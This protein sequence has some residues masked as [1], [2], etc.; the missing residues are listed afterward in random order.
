MT[1]RDI[2]QL[3]AANQ[4]MGQ[5][6]SEI[7][8]A[9]IIDTILEGL[10][11][12]RQ[13]KLKGFGTF[14]LTSVKERESVNVN[15]GERI[16]ISEH[17]KI[18]FTP[19]NVMRDTINKPFAQFETV[20]L[21]DG[22]SFADTEDETLKDET[23][24]NAEETPAVIEETP[25]IEETPVVIEE[26]PVIEE[27]HATEQD[28][29]ISS[30]YEHDETEDISQNADNT[31]TSE[32]N[33]GESDESDEND[34]ESEVSKEYKENDDNINNDEDETV[35]DDQTDDESGS[36][37]SLKCVLITL[38]MVVLIIASFILGFLA[39]HYNWFALNLAKAETIECPIDTTTQEVADKDTTAITNEVQAPT[40]TGDAAENNKANIS[41]P[42]AEN[43]SATTT[44]AK[45]EP[46]HSKPAL[47]EEEETAEKYN[48]ADIRIRTGAYNII[49]IENTITATKG[50]T[51][52]S[53]SKAY[54]GQDMECYIEAVNGGIKELNGGEKI[55]IP[56]L[57][58]KKKH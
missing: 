33:K 32:E 24:E 10:Q 44:S 16:T 37:C 20:T 57:Q 15:T 39:S 45:A 50:Q 12:D 31:S 11:R 41:A 5:T 26:N 3:I 4:G 56:K 25:A 9:A 36:R 21:A 19:D 27:E 34:D 22:V 53:I 51:I 35:D 58:L 28:I 14:K 47:S 8:L 48:E 38:L 13:V 7:F 6:E 23:E 54:L 42:K 52:T 43:A 29:T 55:K 18:T 30:L 46:S 40:Q 49:G 17:D 2:A 1:I